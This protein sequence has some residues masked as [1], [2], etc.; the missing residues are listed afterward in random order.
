MTQV[1]GGDVGLEVG[2]GLRGVA[3]GDGEA[4]VVE[5]PRERPALDEEVDVEAGRQDLLEQS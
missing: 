2:V 1:L 5:A 4:G 3:G